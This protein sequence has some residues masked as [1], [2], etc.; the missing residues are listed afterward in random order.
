MQST[1]LEYAKIPRSDLVEV[2]AI[3]SAKT[4]YYHVTCLPFACRAAVVCCT[5]EHALLGVTEATKRLIQKAVEAKGY[6]NLEW[7][8]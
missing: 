4:A 1:R 7:M 5:E 6:E 2:K 8:S 3:N